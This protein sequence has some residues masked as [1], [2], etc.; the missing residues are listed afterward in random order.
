MSI[1]LLLAFPIS[2]N[3]RAENACTL[4][5]AQSRKISNAVESVQQKIAKW[6]IHGKMEKFDVE[7]YLTM[8][9]EFEGDPLLHPVLGTV[10]ED[11]AFTEANYRR[12]F[13]QGRFSIEEILR[14]D[15]WV[16]KRR[17]Y[18]ILS[19]LKFANGKTA[20]KIR[21]LFDDLQLLQDDSRVSIWDLVKPGRQARLDRAL[22]VEFESQVARRGL[23]KTLESL[24]LIR[25]PT[26]WGYALDLLK[27]PHTQ[28]ALNL[29][30]NVNMVFPV[31]HIYVG[32][33]PMIP[34]FKVGG[35]EFD[36]ILLEG[37]TE[38][39]WAAFSAK[40]GDRYT[41]GHVY[42]AASSIVMAVTLTVM[43]AK[44]VDKKLTEDADLKKKSDASVKAMHD[45]T[46]E[47][48]AENAQEQSTSALDDAMSAWIDDYM[49]SHGGSR[50]DTTGVDY[51]K[52]HEH[53]AEL[54]SNVDEDAKN[55]P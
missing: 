37:A 30:A 6:R 49:K 47:I 34:W 51:K 27:S 52:A 8:R 40:Y 5:F 29:L 43:I 35:K 31:Y 38:E 25:D 2:G 26:V 17:L 23:Q 1:A 14:G 32:R 10:E 15:D 53:F 48:S 33:L 28:F 44:Y 12:S 39:N 20:R 45:H 16:K 9:E 22:R 46:L 50:A 11:V 13:P 42:A 24:D 21:L 55:D 36:R 19:G 54:F 41:K 18:K 4:L 7:R 3:A